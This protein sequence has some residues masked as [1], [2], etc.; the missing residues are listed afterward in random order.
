[1]S[2]SSNIFVLSF[3]LVEDDQ[4]C[5]SS[6]GMLNPEYMYKVAII[7]RTKMYARCNKENITIKIIISSL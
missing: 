7:T 5:L 4:K 3:A 6:S 1:M 2:H